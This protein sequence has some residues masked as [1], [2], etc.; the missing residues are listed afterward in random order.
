MLVMRTLLTFLIPGCVVV[1]QASAPP[2]GSQ[3]REILARISQVALRYESHCPDFSCTQLTDRNRDDSGTG[4][5][6]K[7]QESLEEVASYLD[8]RASV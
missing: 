2:T 4:E 8:G 1:G 5:Q 3:Q 6:W 7:H